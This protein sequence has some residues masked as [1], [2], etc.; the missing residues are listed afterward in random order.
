M[1]TK[2]QA[3][4][5]VSGIALLFIVAACSSGGGEVSTGSPTTPFL[6]G[7]N[8]LEISFLEGSP[9]EEVIDGNSFDF[10]AIVKLV[11]V[12][13]DDF[14]DSAGVDT[15]TEIEISL[16]GFSPDDFRSNAGDFNNEDLDDINPTDVP[17]PR[18]RDSEGNVI[19]PV[20]TFIEFP[21]EN[22]N[23]KFKDKLAGN[24]VFVFR[25]DVCYKYQTKAVSEMCVLENQVDVDDSALCNPSE[26]KSVF[27]SGS[28]LKVTGFRQSVVGSDKT[29]ISFDIAHVGP[30]SVFNL[31][32]TTP[33]DPSCPKTPTGRRNNENKIFVTVETGVDNVEDL[34]CVGLVEGV[35]GSGDVIASGVVK[36]VNGRRTITCTQD[37]ED[38]RSDF[39]RNVDI[40]LDYNYLD[41]ADKEVLVKHVVG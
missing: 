23:F 18:Q 8:G 15:P 26:T 14:A 32:S 20:E 39:K 34:N 24:T 33:D 29:Q 9:P 27:S 17:I 4:L 16:I 25:A 12:G 11:N 31:D 19:E 6:G 30:G 22:A 3:Q 28:P 38:G 35:V 5:I 13:E 36:L 7:S 21:K 40:T 41:S 10:Q 2:K 37:L 1:S